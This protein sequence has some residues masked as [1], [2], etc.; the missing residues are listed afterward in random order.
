[1]KTRHLV[2]GLIAIAAIL[3]GIIFFGCDGDCETIPCTAKNPCDYKGTPYTR[4]ERCK[5]EGITCDDI[6]GILDCNCET[7]PD[8]DKEESLICECT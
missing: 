8:D 3:F 6:W 1:M 5:N 4:G 2:I 7:A